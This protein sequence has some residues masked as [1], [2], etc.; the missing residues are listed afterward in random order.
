MK[1]L[2]VNNNIVM[3]GNGLCT[4]AL[5]TAKY[6]RE[7]GVEVKFLAGKSEGEEAP[8]EPEFPLENIHVPVFQYIIERNGFRFAHRQKAVIK[9][10]V[11]WADVIHIE[12]PFWLQ[13]AVID[14]AEE[15]GKPVV[16]TF[17]LY[18]QNILVEISNLLWGWPNDTYMK[19]WK[20]KYYDHC[21]HISCPTEKVKKLL[22]SY[23]FKAKLHV[24]SNG[25]S[26]PDGPVQV[27]E[28]QTKPYLIMSVGRYSWV[29]GQATILEAM[30]YSK[31]SKEIQLY[32]AGKGNLADYL[33]K[34]AQQLVKEGVLKYA[35]KFKFVGHHQIAEVSRKAYL[36]V[37]AAKLEVE[38]LGCIE[39]VR[40]GAV[41]VIGDGE[42]VGTT[43]FALDARSIF[44]VNDP[45][46]LAAKIDYW[47]DNPQIRNEMSLKYAEFARNF[48]IH[49]SIRKL[50]SMYNEAIADNA[51]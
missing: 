3:K 20:R 32:F 34:Q 50:I 35:P 1:V 36:Y 22:E 6:L 33:K 8:Q 40:E 26:F 24:I 16:G 28:P 25:I 5:M 23:D 48:D 7:A 27:F 37:H 42:L 41:P 30:R 19:L 15:I 11:D 21:S 43:D 4:S 29:K 47:I 39:A 18:T 9:K 10:A 38:G 51:S 49:E 17:H 45:K 44:K 12:E 14:Y 31:H 13:K 2:F 46:D